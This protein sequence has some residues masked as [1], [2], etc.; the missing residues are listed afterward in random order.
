MLVS[1]GLCGGV[2]SHLYAYKVFRAVANSLSVTV[3]KLASVR[4]RKW[5]L[6]QVYISYDACH[7]YMLCLDRK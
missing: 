6:L 4:D 2:P 5:G 7:F 3:L 1:A